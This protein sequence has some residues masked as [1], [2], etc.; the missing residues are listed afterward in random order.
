VAWVGLTVEQRGMVRRLSAEGLSLR[1][2]A[3]QVSCSHQTAW[4]VLRGKD[5]RWA[6]SAW[7]PAEGRLSV[8]ER[9]EI[10][11]GGAPGRDLQRDRVPVGQ[12]DVYGE[13]RGGR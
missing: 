6:R 7:E 4:L 1:Q 11:L 5:G 10:S 9:E 2:V 13:P 12:G 8:A 3:R